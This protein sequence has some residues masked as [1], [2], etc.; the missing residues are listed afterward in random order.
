MVR[1]VERDQE[2]FLCLSGVNLHWL[3]DKIKLYL[4][5]NCKNTL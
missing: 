5:K 3:A 1:H 4:L 2:N